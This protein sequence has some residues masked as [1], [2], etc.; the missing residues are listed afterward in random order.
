MRLK[1]LSLMLALALLLMP[2]Q[3]AQARGGQTLTV[4]AA[5]SLTDVFEEIATAF[6]AAH[7]GVNVIFNFA[8]SST[9]ATQLSE[10]LV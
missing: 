3:V 4:F 6:E 1:A 5:A 9:L 10:G 2:W 7:P 8:G